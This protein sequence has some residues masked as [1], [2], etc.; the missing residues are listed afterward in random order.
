MTRYPGLVVDID[1]ESSHWARSL[2]RRM[3]V[4]RRRATTSKLEIPDGAFKE[5]K[6]QY[7]YDIVTRV[8]KYKIPE[9]LL[10]NIDQTLTKYVHVSQSLLAK[11]NT[12]QVTIKGSS[13]RSTTAH[14]L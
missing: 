11:K 5:I 13:D 10:I 7:L 6:Y 1:I 8:E 4:A 12:K 14:L 9:S 2:F 3:G